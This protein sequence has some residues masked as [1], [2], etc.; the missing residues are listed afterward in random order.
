M[1]ASKKRLDKFPKRLKRFRQSVLAA[2]CS[3]K[4]TEDWREGN[5]NVQDVYIDLLEFENKRITEFKSKNNYKTFKF[6]D[7]IFS[8]EELPTTWKI[9]KIGYLCDCIVPGRDKPKTFSGTIPWITL[10]DIKSDFIDGISCTNNLSNKEIAEVNA[11]II[12]SNSVIISCIGRFGIS[13]INTREIVINQQLHAYLQSSIILSKYLM[14]YMKTMT[15]YMQEVSTATTVAY[16]NKDNCNSIPINLPPLKEQQEIVRRVEALFAIADQ[17]EARYKKAQAYVEKLT[18]SILA[19]AFRGELV[20]Q[21]PND[22]SAS[23][24]LERI[25][26]EKEN[27]IT[28]QKKTQRIKRRAHKR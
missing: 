11:R 19:K 1:E 14:Y 2:A 26:A 12:P 7:S 5:I 13:F 9:A 25:N 16:L 24:L 28:V 23:V 4:L 20:P 10:P 22:E 21:D 17:L 6:E 15:E 18:Q 8:S 3:G 27:N